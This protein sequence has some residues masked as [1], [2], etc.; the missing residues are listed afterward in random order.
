[1]ARDY[2]ALSA[3]LPLTCRDMH[4]LD[5]SVFPEG[6][7]QETLK[8]LALLFPQND[9]KTRRWLERQIKSKGLDNSLLKCGKLG[10]YQRQFDKFSYWHDRLIILKQ[11][12][13]ETTPKNIRQFWYDRRNGMHWYTFWFAIIILLIV[14]LLFG[15]LQT[16]VG[17]LQVALSLK[18]VNSAK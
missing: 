18:A 4:S 5:R 17:A 16:V 8:T 1:M 10:V 9:R 2:L 3:S 6:L 12:F 15:I 14:T 13:D 7:T 11:T